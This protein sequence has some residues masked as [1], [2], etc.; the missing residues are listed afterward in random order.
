[1]VSLVRGIHTPATAAVLAHAGTVDKYVGDGM[2]AFWNAPLQ[3]PDHAANACRAALDIVGAMRVFHEP[4]IRLGIGIHTGEAC[5]GN[6]GSEQRL[7][8]SALGDAVNVAS[9]VEG[10][11]K[12]YGVDIIVTDATAEVATGLGFLE[13]DRVRVK[14]RQG[15]TTLF[16]IHG[17]GEDEALQRLQAV[18]GELLK[19]YRRGDKK[20]ALAILED[21]ELV[22]GSRY[23]A[24]RRH[25]LGR[26]AAMPEITPPEWDGVNTLD[27]K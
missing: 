11:T 15:V 10:L 4:P 25:Y 3:D 19:S 13:L 26:V 20:I 21:E 17:I 2:M 22:Y 14:G 12:L 7:E 16:V 18:H 9:R 1:V 5:V 6:L 8:Y 24:L 27:H 23:A